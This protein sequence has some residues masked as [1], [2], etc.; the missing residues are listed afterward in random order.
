MRLK[1]TLIDAL[2]EAG[3]IQKESFGKSTNISVKE[4]V[5]SI[6][7]EVDLESEKKIVDIIN[8]DFPEH[9]IITE[10]SGFSINNS[11]Y[12]W[13]IDP[14]DGTS[15]YAS[16][17]PW[18]GI[19]IAVFK[20]QEPV[21]SGAY[22][23]VEEKLY[24]AEKGKGAYLNDMLLKIQDK[25]LKD[26]L[27]AFST[28]YTEDEQYLNKGMELYKYIVNNSRNVRTTNS[29]VDLMYVAEGKFGGCINLFNMIWDIAAPYLII[30]EAGGVMKGLD[31][32]EIIF[33][34]TD[35]PVNKDYAIIT[36]A[37]P[38]VKNIEEFLS[39]LQII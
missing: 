13:V 9:N 38:V 11:G 1:S 34:L 23:P 27:F 39:A 37:E 10:E 14:L 17:I 33:E 18:F 22:L 7:T 6:V 29:L 15:N 5:S 19:L 31:R 3:K 20:N 16:G 28:D 35:N 25:D 4:S 36:G 2:T 26:V 8:K 30:K 21:M 32:K 12:T 24:Y